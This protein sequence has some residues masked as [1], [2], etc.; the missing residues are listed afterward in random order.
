MDKV[1]FTRSELYALVWKFPMIEIARHYEISTMGIKNACDK[2][3]LPI[4]N[5]RHWKKPLYKR[6]SVPVLQDNYYGSDQIGILKKTYETWVRGNAKATPLIDLAARIMKDQNAPLTV[7]DQLENSAVI[8]FPF[9]KVADENRTRAVLFMKGLTKLLQYR[10]HDFKEKIGETGTVV[11]ADGIE[12]DLLLR[13]ALKRVPP[14]HIKEKSEYVFTGE[15]ILRVTKNSNKK[16][17]RD[18]KIALENM[19]ALIVAKLE[20]MADEER[21]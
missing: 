5:N 7:P 13:E 12:I 1:I 17:W 14:N 10:G 21:Q 4:P 2:M 6:N 11:F 8:E 3:Q 16:E 9:L 15:F 19:L 20:I 18:G